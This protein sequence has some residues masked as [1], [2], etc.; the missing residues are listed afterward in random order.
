MLKSD[1]MNWDSIARRYVEHDTLP[2]ETFGEL[3]KMTG[4][5]FDAVLEFV[6]VD[7]GAPEGDKTVYWSPPSNDMQ[8]LAA[9]NDAAIREIAVAFGAKS[10][11]DNDNRRGAFMQTFSARQ[12]WPLDA[13]TAEVHLEDIAHSLS[14]QCRYAGHCLRFYSV[15]EHCV[16]IARWIWWHSTPMNALIGLLHDATEAYLVDMPRPVKR[17]LH[18]YRLHEAALWKVIAARYGLPEEMPEIVHEADNRII[19]DELVNMRPMAWH[20]KHNDPLGVSLEF[21]SPERAEREFLDV[22]GALW[23]GSSL[24]GA[25]LV[26]DDTYPQHDREASAADRDYQLAKEEAG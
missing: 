1:T 26:A 25:S 16:H 6:G 20:A 19:A 4:A 17:S 24:V 14:L 18:E 22:F 15:A 2:Q 23:S 10:A 11:N 12:F 5:D 21:W 8:Q 13:R 7:R 9:M 3:P